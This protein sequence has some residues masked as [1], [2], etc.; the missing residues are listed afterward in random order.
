MNIFEMNLSTS[1]LTD[2][3]GI[4]VPTLS[5]KKYFMIDNQVITVKSSATKPDQL[6]PLHLNSFRSRFGLVPESFTSIVGADHEGYHNIRHERMTYIRNVS[7][8]LMEYRCVIPATAYFAVILQNA[9]ARAYKFSLINNEPFLMA[10]L[11]TTNR[12]PQIQITSCGV[13]TQEVT[14]PG[15]RDITNRVPLTFDFTGGCEWLRYKKRGKGIWKIKNALTE[16]HFKVEVLESMPFSIDASQ[17][18][19]PKA[20]TK[21]IRP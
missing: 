13:V 14:E 3:L 7:Q 6:I 19:K 2:W 17:L 15:W 9:K 8:L 21:T 5:L 12:R 1:Q 4:P 10:G 20:I 11:W 16:Q 18:E